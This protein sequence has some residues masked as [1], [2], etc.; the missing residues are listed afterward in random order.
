M[1]AR[2]GVLALVVF[3]AA[4]SA[5]ADEAA[6]PDF[7]KIGRTFL[8][9]HCLKCHG[10]E[11]PKADL[12]LE[13]FRDAASLVKQRKL[14]DN[15]RKMLANGE[16]P[17]SGQ[18]QPP[19][20]E[21][22]AFTDLVKA[23]FDHA[24]RNAKPDPGRVTMRRLNRVEYRNTIR[25]LIGVSFDPTEDFPSDDIGHGFDNIG[26]VLS[27]SPVLMERYLAAAESIMSQA[28]TPNPPAVIKR[29][30]AS[31]YTEPASPES[32]KL[33][34]KG[35]RRM[36]TDGQRA[37]DVGP[38]NTPYNWEA[39][40][41]YIFRTR[42]YGESGTDQ[43]LRVAI[44]V[45]GKDLPDP[46]PDAELARL[47]GNVQRPARLLK[48]FAVQAT[49]RE[50]AE[51]LEVRVPPIPNRH[52]MMIAIDK[53]GEGQPPAYLMVEY[54]QLDGPLDPRPASHRRL[55]AV[56]PGTAL[57]EQS[58]EVMARFLR[59]AYRRPPSAEELDRVLRLVDQALAEGEKWEAAMQLAMQATLC[60]PKFLFR[61]EL[62][63]NPQSPN[64]RVLDEFQLA[65]RLSY[66]LW[67]SMP[68]DTLLDLAEKGQLTANL[69][70]QV[71]R[72]LADP[73]AVALVENF[74]MQ[75]LQLKRIEF[76]SPDGK[77]FPTFNVKLRGAMVRETELFL[78][79]ILR[80]DRS[81]LE[82]ID[83]DYTF[84]NE[85][86]ARHY[87]IADTNGN[88]LGEKPRMPRG[89][90]IKGD[91]FRRVTLPDRTR[92]GLLTQASV[93][94]VTSNPTRTSPVKRGRWVLEQ[95][96]GAPPPPP[97]PNVPELSEE[98]RDISAASLRQRMEVHRRN[99]A[100]ANCHAKMDPIGFA[101]ENFNAVGAWRDKDGEFDI[102]ATG[103][104]TD[105][106]KFVGPVE[107]K[108]FVLRRKDDFVRCMVE[109]LLIYALGRGLEYYDRP[110]VEQIVRALPAE[111]YKF[112][113]LVIQIVKSDPFRKRRGL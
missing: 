65:S 71:R 55:L 88:L 13:P 33:V 53:P 16:M 96:L 94:T 23:I 64:I 108:T 76:I 10:G 75:W 54:L 7:G 61:A 40:G 6:F 62:D 100:C 63:D 50:E 85:P 5:H 81:I 70:E 80:E 48:T 47:S 19:V 98:E 42:V 66:F 67:S 49:R 17:P 1:N 30:L 95:I 38:I 45:H 107:L 2:A 74:A 69:E 28:I 105:G 43:P 29:H 92:G 101:L 27:L 58:R 37:I 90:P 103:E 32:G 9:N 46:S 111:N 104:F 102:D 60:S 83:A 35:F 56:T 91:Q 12:S 84:L 8:E 31:V 51:I 18:P 79:S 11:R 15:V 22:V 26:D 41:E 59:R 3:L 77:L 34:E 110:T 112:S 89:Q 93:L 97:P 113:A 109:K 72:M 68:D 44:L 21:T 14:W 4:S 24:D 73:R 52:R 78:E 99:V 87:G 36:T 57:E 20:A 86:L 82:L 39:D 25:D 106:T